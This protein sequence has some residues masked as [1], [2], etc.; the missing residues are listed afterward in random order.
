M[1]SLYVFAC[2]GPGAGRV[3]AEAIRYGYIS[4]GITLALSLA[5]ATLYLVVRHNLRAAILNISPMAIHPAWTI[6][7]G[8][9]DCGIMKVTASHLWIGMT[10]TLL[11]VAIL[12]AVRRGRTHSPTPFQFSIK[13][14]LLLMLATATTVA[15]L[16]T[17]LAEFV[18]LIGFAALILVALKPI[19]FFKRIMDNNAAK[20]QNLRGRVRDYR[21]V[22]DVSDDIVINSR[23]SDRVRR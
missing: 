18:P 14:L 1:Q 16:Q 12:I 23:I 10:T 19:A 21:N 6:S 15:L 7:A 5:T 13:S 9:G 8:G 4:A 3:I 17:P 2:S 11:I 22:P 20:Q